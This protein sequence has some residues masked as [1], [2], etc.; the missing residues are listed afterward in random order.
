[1]CNNCSEYVRTLIEVKAAVCSSDVGRSQK[2]AAGQNA[3]TKASCCLTADFLID[4]SL[5]ALL[6]FTFQQWELIQEN[7]KMSG[8]T[9]QDP[10]DDLWSLEERFYQEGYQLGVADGS[11]SGRI[12]GRIFGL[13]KGFEK[14]AAMGS[15]AGQCAVWEARMS[16]QVN[17]EELKEDNTNEIDVPPL[18]ENA[19]LRKHFQTLSALTEV[20]SLSTQNNEEA[21]T[22]F[23]DRMNRAE[24]KT[25]VIQS[26][27]GE[28]G[29]TDTGNS[30]SKR[31][32]KK[33]NN[34][35]MEDFAVPK[36]LR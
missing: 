10:L 22:D 34:T 20:E 4:K 2:F 25:K 23:D 33:S 11:R 12:E 9:G 17:S 19:R 13:E 7:M 8:N 5:Y 15:L 16:K 3:H 32:T 26:I 35:N 14:F 18:P 31:T 21:V 24:G 28:T 27:L 30:T 36:A 6:C 29:S 1:M